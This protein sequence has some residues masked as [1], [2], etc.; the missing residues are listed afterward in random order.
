MG[1]AV[2]SWRVFPEGVPVQELLERGDQAAGSGDLISAGNWYFH[3]KRRGSVEGRD[4]TRRLQPRL[5]VLA[6][7][8]DLDAKVLVAGLLLERGEHLPFAASLLEVAAEANVIQGMRELGFVLEGGIGVTPDP[9]R[10]NE[11]YRAAA[12][13]GDGYAAF[14]LAVNFY[15]GH[16][17]GKNFREFAKWL[18]IAGDLGIPEACAVLGDQ[19]AKKGLDG[20]SLQWYLRAASSS[21]V[22]AMLVAARRYRD[23]IGTPIDPVQAVRWFLTPLDRGNGDGIHDA[24]E[25]ASS[26]TVEQIREAGRLSGHVDEAELLLR[27]R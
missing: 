14:N 1:E 16:G 6:D 27:G 3:A 12:E 8:G 19:C 4:K 9:V 17:T 5:E 13:A 18:Q 23:G 22:P 24:I 7:Q 26:M 11:L 2:P 25:L 20:D 15:R 10:A 21:H